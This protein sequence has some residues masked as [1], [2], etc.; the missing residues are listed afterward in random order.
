MEAVDMVIVIQC[1]LVAFLLVSFKSKHH[2]SNK[3]LASFLVILALQFSSKLAI[4]HALYTSSF[5]TFNCFYGF[6]YGP[7]L[8]FYTNTLLFKE[9][10]FKLSDLFHLLP[11][12]AIVALYFFNSI[13]CSEITP[14]IYVSITIYIALSLKQ[15]NTYRKICVQ[16]QSS[17]K[18]LEMVWLQWTIILIGLTLILE[19]LIQY[20]N[21]LELTATE[22]V[23]HLA[24]LIVINIIFYKSLKQPQL[25][26]GL[27]YNNKALTGPFVEEQKSPSDKKKLDELNTYLTTSKIFLQPE[28]TIFHLSEMSK[29][30]VH[31][32]SFIINYYNHLTFI[33]YI[34]SFRIN[35]AKKLIQTNSHSDCK[36]SD[37]MIKS[38]FNSLKA[39]KKAFKTTTGKSFSEYKKTITHSNTTG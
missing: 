29:I 39:F 24:V 6:L 32:I 19:G 23:I 33:S 30:S 22:M 26:L 14:L 8:Y 16:T 13:N 20:F 7:I 9:Y 27:S 2:D 38:G 18:A 17:S 25:F 5:V 3:F 15:L 1:L 34:N 28:L 31:D 11:V 12:G 37:I 21:K 10:H 36:A 35:F 4:D